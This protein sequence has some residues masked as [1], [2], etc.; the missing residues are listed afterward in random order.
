MYLSFFQVL[1][2]LRLL[3]NIEQSSLHYTI[4][5]YWLSILNIKQCVYGNPKSVLHLFIDEQYSIYGYTRF[6]LPI[7]GGI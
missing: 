5:P 7:N 1:F 3:Q 2:P 4:G 6:C